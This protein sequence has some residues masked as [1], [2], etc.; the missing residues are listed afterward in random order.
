MKY[1]LAIFDMDGT[2][3]NTLDDLADSLNYSLSQSG[4]PERTLTEVRNFVGNG[5][6]KLIERGMPAD[7]SQNEL[8]Q[9]YECFNGYYKEHCHDKT[10]PYDG[11]TKM[12]KK[13]REHGIKTAVVSNKADFAVRLL[14]TQYFEGLFDTAAGEKSGVRKKPAPDSV[15]TVLSELGIS[16]E[17]AV[18]IGDSDVDVMTAVNSKMNCICVDW[19]FRDR[20]FLIKNGADTIVSTTDQLLEYLL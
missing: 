17:K 2:I 3:L 19:G 20:D 14:C 5:I 8:Q 6:K 9:A 1:E 15:N 16:R 4:Y 7:A 10:K 11:I 12:L 18:Y 13:L